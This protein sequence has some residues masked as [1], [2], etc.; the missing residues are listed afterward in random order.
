VK[1]AE[2]RRHGNCSVCMTDKDRKNAVNSTSVQNVCARTALTDCSSNKN[3]L[4]GTIIMLR[5]LIHIRFCV[6]A[7]EMNGMNKTLFF[8]LNIFHFVFE[9]TYAIINRY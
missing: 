4:Q 8:L 6:V 5:N 9:S 7:W 2:S 1:E 3:Q